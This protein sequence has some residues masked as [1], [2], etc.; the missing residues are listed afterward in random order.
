VVVKVFQT[1][2]SVDWA[3]VAA[4]LAGAAALAGLGGLVA[5]FQALSQRPAPALR[6]E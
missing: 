5:A 6:G 2:W 3:G 4:L 1:H